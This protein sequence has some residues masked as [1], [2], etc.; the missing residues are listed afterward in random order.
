MEITTDQSQKC[1]LDDLQGKIIPSTVYIAFFQRK[2]QQNAIRLIY[3]DESSLRSFVRKLSVN[4][5]PIVNAREELTKKGFLIK[6]DEK[7]RASQFQSSIK[8]LI[9]SVRREI[10]KNNS[11]LINFKNLDTN[12]NYDV[13]E[14]ILNSEIFRKFFDHEIL[15][16]PFYSQNT[17]ELSNIQ[18]P[19]V[20]LIPSYSAFKKNLQKGKYEVSDIKK[21]LLGLIS[22]L[23]IYSFYL[24]RLL[25]QFSE[26]LPNSNFQPIDL[27]IIL[28]SSSFDLLIE[29][30]RKNIPFNFINEYF[31]YI[32]SQTKIT[33]LI[34]DEEAKNKGSNIMRFYSDTQR[35]E[36]LLFAY[37]E[38]NPKSPNFQ[39]LAILFSIFVPLDIA[40]LMKNCWNIPNPSV[41]EKCRLF[42]QLLLKNEDLYSKFARYYQIKNR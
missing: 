41:E 33:A 34:A 5:S 8:P 4:I 3:S 17:F 1:S 32:F 27:D 16:S 40:Y 9:N 31:D 42:E 13:L 35:K 26:N 18:I 38:I 11:Y 2:S 36:G 22:E 12:D 39:H 25:L 37:S 19:N 23:G 14:M 15:Y 28:K 29:N 21:L 24:Q 30:H 20:N 10:S 7:L 6:T